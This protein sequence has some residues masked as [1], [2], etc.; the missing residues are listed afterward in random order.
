MNKSSRI[1]LLL[2]L[3]SSMSIY[4]SARQV[5]PEG[6]F[7]Y[8][9]PE[10]WHV[11]IYPGLKYKIVVTIQVDNFMPNMT[12]VTEDYPGDLQTYKD[13]NIPSMQTAVP[14]FRL[15]E[16]YSGETL[17]GQPYMVVRYF[18]DAAESG[19]LVQTA[20]LLKLSGDTKLV[21]TCTPPSGR[22]WDYIGS[23]NKLVRSI[24]VE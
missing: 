3:L 15:V 20:Y 6:G 13:A 18:H 23:C 19:L 9:V 2:L 7:S 17:E 14:G 5:E 16:E 8:E 21:V 4:A 1:V 10:D 22:E 24:R 12:F 11:D